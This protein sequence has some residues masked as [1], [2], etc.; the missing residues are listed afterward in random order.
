MLMDLLGSPLAHRHSLLVV[1]EP[2]AHIGAVEVLPVGVSLLLPRGV[3]WIAGRDEACGHHG[4]AYAREHLVKRRG[5]NGCYG[6][7][8]RRFTLVDS[9]P[10]IQ[11]G[12]ADVQG[13]PCGMSF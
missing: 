2:A 5:G 11:D 1:S 10:V 7:T 12:A 6:R 8:T 3:C 9:S 4:H 13:R